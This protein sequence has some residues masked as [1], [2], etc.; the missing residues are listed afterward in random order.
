MAA[1]L[2]FFKRI[3][4]H[5]SLIFVMAMQE[6][7]KR[8]VG[9]FAGFMW[10]VI[11]P[12]M[13][14]LVFWFVFSVGFK[15]QPMGDIP[16][17]VIFFCGFIPWLTFSETLLVNTNSLIA[18]QHL[19]NKVVF[20][21]EILPIINLIAS[22]IS[23]AVM[24]AILLILLFAYGLPLSIYNLQFIY[25]LFAMSAFILG[26]SWLLSALNVFFR[27]TSQ[28]IT[29]IVNMWFWFTPI[30]WVIDMVPPQ[31]RYII[32]LN[33]MY[34]IVSGYKASFVYHAPFWDSAR[35]GLY[36]W[37][38]CISVFLAGGYVFRRLKPEFAD[39]L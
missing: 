35:L 25:Y 36:F 24:L 34:Y 5:R 33:P 21:T 3:Y 29:V 27:D 31:Y 12:V 18:N 13:T 9:T 1:L 11:N 10:T 38:I 6:V 22:F 19:V 7:K 14:I 2:R 17:A 15:V 32:K 16:F 23:H 37:V 28:I 39:L 20:P 4:L 30:V 8:Y 26:L